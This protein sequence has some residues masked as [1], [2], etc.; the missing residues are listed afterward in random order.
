MCIDDNGAVLGRCVHACNG[1]EDCETECLRTFKARQNNCPCEENCKGGCP[2]ENFS[3]IDTTT[4]SAVTNPTMPLT[5]TARMSALAFF[6]H[7]F[8]DRPGPFLVT[9]GTYGPSYGYWAVYIKR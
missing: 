8:R 1:A 2:C 9:N 4:T 3:C 7:N 5:T 6:G